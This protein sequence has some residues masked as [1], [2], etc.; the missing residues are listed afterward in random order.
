CEDRPRRLLARVLR[1][2]CARL[3]LLRGRA[4][5]PPARRS[6][7]GSSGPLTTGEPPSPR[8]LPWTDAV[9][10]VPVAVAPL[11]VAPVRVVRGRSPARARSRWSPPSP[12]PPAA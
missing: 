1:V 8:G 4:T 5:L 3:T 12:S 10:V 9:P 6:P 2:R 11:P 7:P